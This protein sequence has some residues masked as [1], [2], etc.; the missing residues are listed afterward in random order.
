MSNMHLTLA[1]L[2]IGIIA[3]VFLYN[4]WSIRRHLSR[5][6]ADE[7]DGDASGAAP[8]APAAEAA[9]GD[10]S[11]SHPGDAAMPHEAVLDALIFSQIGRAHV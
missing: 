4:T 1:I 7:A 2:G 9:E 3:A 8:T 11:A 6:A 5:L 10:G